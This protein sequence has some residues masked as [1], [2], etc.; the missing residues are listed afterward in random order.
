MFGL[1]LEVD[2][3]DD[4]FLPSVSASFPISLRNILKHL[5]HSQIFDSVETELR[6][7]VRLL[8]DK[9][10]LV[11]RVRNHTNP[12]RASMTLNFHIVVLSR[13]RELLAR[14]PSEAN[15]WKLEQDDAEGEGVGGSVDQKNCNRHIPSQLFHQG[16]WI[17]QGGVWISSASRQ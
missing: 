1:P 10:P 4:H 13:H 12:S 5:S 2:V 14:C 7:K 17:S 9:Y 16:R 6:R 15:N 3:D 11:A 8:L